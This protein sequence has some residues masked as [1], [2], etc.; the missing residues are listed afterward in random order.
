MKTSAP[1]DLRRGSVSLCQKQSQN[2]KSAARRGAVIPPRGVTFA[3]S[4]GDMIN[5]IYKKRDKKSFFF[6]NQ[7]V[8]EKNRAIL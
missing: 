3:V 6:K 8:K 5:K 1:V 4:L 2:K 7:L